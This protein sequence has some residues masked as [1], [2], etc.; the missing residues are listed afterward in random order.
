MRIF[1]RRAATGWSDSGPDGIRRRRIG[2]S[3]IS[4]GRFTYGHEAMSIMQWGEG[5][6]LEVGA[7]CSIAKGVTVF[8]GG[9]HRVDWFTTFPFGKIFKAELGA[10]NAPGHPSGKGRVTI[11]NDVWIGAG[12]TI[13]S[14]V[15]I[16]DGAVVA[17]SSV[18]AKDIGPYEIWGGNPARKLRDRFDQD[19][20]SDL[21]EFAWWR[22]P[23][24]TIS[25]IAPSLCAV[26]TQENL[27]QLRED[28][29]V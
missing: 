29:R 6:S 7:F 15:T 13:Y 23:T 2:N 20:T 10:V 21:I 14:G 3:D 18:V 8:L 4:V 28:F 22:L 24:P 17:G 9:N 12:A 16:G 1:K 11:G 5:F 27:R 25:A 26:A 19:L